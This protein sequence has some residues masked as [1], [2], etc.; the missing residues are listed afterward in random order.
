MKWFDSILDKFGLGIDG[1]GE[2][3]PLAF[4]PAAACLESSRLSSWVESAS[5]T[6]LNL[7]GDDVRMRNAGVVTLNAQK[8]MFE[9][10]SLV[11]LGRNYMDTIYIYYSKKYHKNVKLGNYC[12]Q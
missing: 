4:P 5:T 3:T 12:I 7:G 8:D 1:S 11:K 2:A 10:A 6:C 9:H